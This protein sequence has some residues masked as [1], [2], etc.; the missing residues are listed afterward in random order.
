GRRQ[1]LDGYARQPRRVDHDQPLEPPQ[2]AFE[3]FEPLP[4]HRLGQRA[5]VAPSVLA[6]EL[7]VEARGEAPLPPGPGAVR[8]GACDLDPGGIAGVAQQARPVVRLL[9]D[10]ADQG[11]AFRDGLLY[12]LE[13]GGPAGQGAILALEL[14][15]QLEDLAAE[16]ARLAAEPGEE[17]V[18]VLGP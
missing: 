5:G 14:L 8:A 13:G 15:L 17:P 18:L 7:G 10:P 16:V 11:G 6:S 12:G 1:N 9:I 2:L 4:R 3:R